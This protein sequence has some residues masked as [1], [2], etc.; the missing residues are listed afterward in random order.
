MAAGARMVEFAG[1]AMPIFYEG[2]VAEHRR[3]RRDVGIFD[4]SHMGEFIV[5][6]SGAE[7]L[8]ERL[9]TN[10]VAALK[11]GRVQYSAM[12][13]EEGGFID[14]LL[15]YRLPGRYMLVVNA[16]NRQKD[17]EWIRSH[18]TG[19][20]VVEDASDRT[21]LVAIQGPKSEA[22]LSKLSG[23]G[24]SLLSYY[25]AAT[26]SVLGRPTLVSRTGYTGE[27]GFEVYCTIDEVVDVWDGLLEAGAEFGVAPIGLG[28][29]DTLR[30][31]MGYCLYGN[32][33][34][35]TR[36]P[37]EAGLLWI[38]K[39]DQGDFIG[40]DAI[41]KITERG[42]Q[43]RLLGFELIERG[44]PRQG[45]RVL[46]GGGD[47]GVVTSGT[48]SPSLE[49]GI[50]MGYFEAG[51]SLDMEVEIRGRAVAG[52]ITPMPFYRGGSVRRKR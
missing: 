49:K 4:V 26:L 22:V 40:R 15:V 48:F 33:I 45:Q 28:A 30:L 36:S 31:E 6:G 42:P 1:L 50:G 46:A 18:A 3:V 21:A 20:V 19:D 13:R 44:V 52:R 43:R 47:A 9:T 16:S 5:S 41:L 11:Q 7:A 17:L 25:E 29:R 34:D 39:F 27:D 8:L 12:C 10:R 24:L 51:V 38:T 32:D 35:E 37:A 2:I 14:D 23:P